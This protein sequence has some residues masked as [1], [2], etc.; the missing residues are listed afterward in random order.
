MYPLASPLVLTCRNGRAQGA[1]IWRRCALGA[2]DEFLQ[3]AESGRAVV[4][5]WHGSRRFA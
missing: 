4:V 3:V 1:T 5:A 2:G